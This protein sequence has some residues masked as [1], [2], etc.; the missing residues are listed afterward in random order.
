MATSA[1]AP[2]AASTTTSTRSAV[3]DWKLRYAEKVAVD[4][5]GRS[6]NRRVAWVIFLG[7]Q[8]HSA[9]RL[10]PAYAVTLNRVTCSTSVKSI[11]RRIASRLETGKATPPLPRSRQ[12]ASRLLL[13]D[14]ATSAPPTA[15]ISLPVT[16]TK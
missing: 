9:T 12:D 4:S 6:E 14:T 13:G 1:V 15:V 3:S 11:R 2:A 5:P 7:F 8:S 10:L 16:S